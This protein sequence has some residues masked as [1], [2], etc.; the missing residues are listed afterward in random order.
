MHLFNFL[1]QILTDFTLARKF[2][3][4]LYFERLRLFNRIALIS[5]WKD[6]ITTIMF[7]VKQNLSLVS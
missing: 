3:A 1:V 6:T 7:A 5:L 2:N 4:C